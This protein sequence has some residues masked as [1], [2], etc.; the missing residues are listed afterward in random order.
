MVWAGPFFDNLKFLSTLPPP[1]LQSPCLKH[2]WYFGKS[3][4]LKNKLLADILSS[5]CLTQNYVAGHAVSV[6]LSGA[7]WVCH[8]DSWAVGSARST[9]WCRCAFAGVSYPW[10]VLHV[11]RSVRSVA[12]CPP[13]PHSVITLP[14]LV[15][16]VIYPYYKTIHIYHH[17]ITITVSHSWILWVKSSD[18]V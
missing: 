7:C 13:L 1:C 4:G 10:K 14:L 12:V 16:F 5:I 3:G 15:Y 17:K 18:R 8:R 9:N 2:Y 11:N 6:L